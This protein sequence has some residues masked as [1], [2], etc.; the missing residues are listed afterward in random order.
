VFVLWTHALVLFEYNFSLLDD[1]KGINRVVC[2]VLVDGFCF[3]VLQE[4]DIADAR[5]EFD[6]KFADSSS[7]QNTHD[8][9]D[10][11]D[12]L[13]GIVALLDRKLEFVSLLS[14]VVKKW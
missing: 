11:T 6:G 2:K 7:T 4:S 5:V 1:D 13:P 14:P 3:A 9:V 10:A 12:I 8:V